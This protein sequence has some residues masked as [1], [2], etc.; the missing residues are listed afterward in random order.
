MSKA[1]VAVGRKR[2]S[3]LFLSFVLILL[4]P[5]GFSACGAAEIEEP[6]PEAVDEEDYVLS[7]YPVVI[8][9]TAVSARPSRLVSLSPALTEKLYDIG[10]ESVLVGVSD[11]CDYPAYVSALTK[12][13]TGQIPNIERILGLDPHAVLTQTQLSESDSAI[14]AERSIPVIVVPPAR[15]LREWRESYVSL[16]QLL[17]GAY[18]GADIGESFAVDLQR[19]LDDLQRLYAPYAA[20][21][22]SKRVLYLRLLDFTV[23]TG[24]TLEHELLSLIG[25]SNIAADFTDWHY[26]EENAN[27][28]GRAD[29]ES[30]DLIFMDEKFV[31]IT[32]LEQNSFYRGLQ[33]TLQDWY[34]YIDSLVLERQ[35][36]RTLSVLEQMGQAAY[37]EAF[38]SLPF[39]DEPDGDDGGDGDGDDDG[40]N[41]GQ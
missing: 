11:Y 1:G 36:L 40:E 38:P 25:L 28:D 6:E 34:I 33:A 8:Y 21:H 10:L 18:V 39:V 19:R 9:G 16:A 7:E 30:I 5:L 29:F 13:G 14:L 4:L 20:E 41:N 37:P 17:E 35:S 26:P 32:M 23:A 3:L 12:C 2:V 31:T 27:G 24:G 22:G 15:N